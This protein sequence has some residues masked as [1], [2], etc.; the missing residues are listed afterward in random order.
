M[1]NLLAM[2][3]RN[4]RQL[5]VF[6]RRKISTFRKISTMYGV[7]ARISTA[8]SENSRVRK[9]WAV[10]AVDIVFGVPSVS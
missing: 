3:T 7:L 9:F 1:R 5:T 6:V 8:Q 2:S 10:I 4:K